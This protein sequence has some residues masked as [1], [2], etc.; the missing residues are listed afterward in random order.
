MLTHAILLLVSV[1]TVL[2]G[3]AIGLD[4]YF[5]KVLLSS[6][7]IITWLGAAAGSS[8]WRYPYTHVVDNVAIENAVITGT[9]QI[10]GAVSWTAFVWLGFAIIM[11]IYLFAGVA[12]QSEKAWKKKNRPGE[13]SG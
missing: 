8:S 9:H 7:S 11:F 13:M 6:M 5:R 2:T 4:D 3:L 1:G 12:G 10:Q